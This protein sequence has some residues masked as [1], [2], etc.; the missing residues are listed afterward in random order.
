MG[1]LH[2]SN[3][4]VSNLTINIYRWVLYICMYVDTMY[5]YTLT[6]IHMYVCSYTVARTEL[7]CFSLCWIF[8][9][10]VHSWV[11][12]TYTKVLREKT[13]AVDCV[14]LSS[15]WKFY[16]ERKKWQPLKFSHIIF[17]I[18]VCMRIWNFTLLTILKYILYNQ[19]IKRSF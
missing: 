3:N 7:K 18:Y 9:S 14:V 6:S 2:L 8:S 13:F 19:N 11:I 5:L 17:I 4:T 10:S 1:I 12:Y 15:S 16:H